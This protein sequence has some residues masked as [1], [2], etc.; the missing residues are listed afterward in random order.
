MTYKRNAHAD[1]T[2]KEKA[3]LRELWQNNVHRNV[4]GRRIGCSGDAAAN[5]ARKLKLKRKP[6]PIRWANIRRDFLVLTYAKMGLTFEE[7]GKKLG[8]KKSTVAS[9]VQLIRRRK[10]R[11][12]SRTTKYNARGIAMPR[13]DRQAM[14]PCIKCR[15]EFSST[16]PGHRIC[17]PCKNG[18]EYKDAS[19]LP[20]GMAI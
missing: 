7:V 10:E 19:G 6:K 12:E 2:D 3:L 4:I 5:M 18:P 11:R 15:Q 14:R 16:H 17:T 13:S 1:W 20:G 9:R 8:M